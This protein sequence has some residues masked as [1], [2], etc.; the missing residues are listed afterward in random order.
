[1]AVSAPGVYCS[2]S[3]ASCHG[4][5]VA[6]MAL[7]AEIRK[8]NVQK[9]PIDR[10]VR[11]VACKAVFGILCMFENKRSLLFRMALTAGCLN[12]GLPQHL[13]C[14][15]SMRVMTIIAEDPLFRDGMMA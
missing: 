12:R 5:P 7:Q 2:F 8:R 10:P 13:F 11:A 1:M 4:T 6:R 3:F 15:R 14:R 9:I